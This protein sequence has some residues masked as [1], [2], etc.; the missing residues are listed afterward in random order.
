MALTKRPRDLSKDTITCPTCLGK[1]KVPNPDN[2]GDVLRKERLK[3][4]VQQKAI[5]LRMDISG[6]YLSDMEKGRRPMSAQQIEQYREAIQIEKAK[7]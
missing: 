4:G 3:A 1:G 7:E 6:G 2:I 5:A